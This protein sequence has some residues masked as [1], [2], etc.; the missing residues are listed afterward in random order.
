VRVP[1]E[2]LEH[3]LERLTG[4][5]HLL[6]VDGVLV[7]MEELALDA[8]DGLSDVRAPEPLKVCCHLQSGSQR[9]LRQRG[10]CRQPLDPTVA[11]EGK[12]AKPYEGVLL[13]RSRRSELAW[14]G[15]VP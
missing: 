5:D 6:R 7:A 15:L 12:Q 9:G 11:K 2:L 4:L 10:Q 3:A 13:Q 14:W 8:L 1:H